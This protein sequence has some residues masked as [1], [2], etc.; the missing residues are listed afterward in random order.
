MANTYYVNTCV[1]SDYY[2]DRYGN[3]GMPLG[4]YAAKFFLEAIK[5]K[6]KILISDLTIRE[7]KRFYDEI[8]IDLMFSLLSNLDLLTAAQITEDEILEA[9][10]LSEKYTTIPLHDI[11]HAVVSKKHN[12]ILVTQDRHFKELKEITRTRTPQISTNPGLSP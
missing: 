4:K 5:N 9:K 2:E 7:L 10:V 11:L 12:A 8:D 1:W 6:D 3:R